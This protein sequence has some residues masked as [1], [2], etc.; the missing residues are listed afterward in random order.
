MFKT[1][2]FITM[3]VS[4]IGFLSAPN[5]TKYLAI[6]GQELIKSLKINDFKLNFVKN[7]RGTKIFDLNEISIQF[8]IDKK[9]LKEIF[10]ELMADGMIKGVFTSEKFI[11]DDDFEIETLEERNLK[12]FKATIIEYVKPYRW[13]NIPKLAKYFNIPEPIARDEIHNLIRQK[14][15]V[16]FLDGDN[17]IRELS[18]ISIDLSDYPECPYCNNKVIPHS[19]FCSICGKQIDYDIISDK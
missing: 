16:G 14:K 19:K 3:L 2:Q 4:G 6:K 15:I 10:T 17:L 13:L 9:T 18:L 7:F 12:K 8:K 1:P 11:L 5:L